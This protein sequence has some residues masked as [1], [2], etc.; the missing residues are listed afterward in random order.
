MT[1]PLSGWLLRDHTLKV[2]HLLTDGV[3]LC[4][5]STAFAFWIGLRLA[6]LSDPGSALDHGRTDLV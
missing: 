2:K 1:S 4:E 3:L 5:S 6:L